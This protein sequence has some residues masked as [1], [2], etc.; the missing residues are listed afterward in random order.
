V[1]RPSLLT[2]L[3]LLPRRFGHAISFVKPGPEDSPSFPCRVAAIAGGIVGGLGLIAIICAS[4]ALYRSVTRKLGASPST[5]RGPSGFSRGTG[6]QQRFG[7]SKTGGIST[8]G[9]SFAGVTIA[10]TP[11][12]G[13]PRTASTRRKGGRGPNRVDEFR[14]SP[15]DDN[16]SREDSTAHM[17][18]PGAISYAT[19]MHKPSLSVQ[20]RTEYPPPPQ[21]QSPGTT[22]VQLELTPVVTSADDPSSDLWQEP[23]LAFGVPTALDEKRTTEL[24]DVLIQSQSRNEHNR[25][26]VPARA[27]AQEEEHA[28]S[29]HPYA[30]PLASVNP[31]PPPPPSLRSTGTSTGRGLSSPVHNPGSNGD[32]DGDGD[33]DQAVSE[34]YAFGSRRGLSMQAKLDGAGSAFSNRS[35]ENEVEVE[36]QYIRHTDAGVIKVVELPPLYHDVQR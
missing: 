15:G 18:P 28:W 26:R 6:S 25:T 5:N 31:T 14:M 7:S 1:S 8:G 34:E 30:N 32:R 20:G 9:K 23:S 10:S 17:L 36:T 4:I 11:K 3:L 16:E 13:G 21:Q 12:S 2:S 22:H 24:D 29:A 35:R 33:G 19:S 27:P